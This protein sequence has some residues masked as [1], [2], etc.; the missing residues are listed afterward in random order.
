MLD[1]ILDRLDEAGVT[2]AVVNL[3][4]LGEMIEDHLHDGREAPAVTFSRE[5]D[6]LETGGGIMQG[7]AAAG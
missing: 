5:D 3:H 6:R 2:K 4:Y 7:L 1:I